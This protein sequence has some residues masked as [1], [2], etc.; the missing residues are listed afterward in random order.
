MKKQHIKILTDRSWH[1][2]TQ[3][4]E[5][6]EKN[7]YSTITYFDGGVLETAQYKIG[8]YAGNISVTRKE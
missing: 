5:Y 6:I 2:L 8:L 4:K 3:L 7:N 1:S